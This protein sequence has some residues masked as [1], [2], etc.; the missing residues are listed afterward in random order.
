MYKIANYYI[1]DILYY[2]KLIIKWNIINSYKKVAFII[3]IFLFDS[4]YHIN[5]IKVWNLLSI[6]IIKYLV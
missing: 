3:Y 2:Q 1:I 5:R 4:Y 6:Y